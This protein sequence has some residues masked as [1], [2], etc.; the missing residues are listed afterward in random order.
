MYDPAKIPLPPN[1][2][3][4]HPFDNGELKVRDE[5]LAPFPRTPEVIREHI[6]AYYGMIS[7]LDAQVGRVLDALD[8]TGHTRDTIVIFAGDNGLAVGR[9]GLMGKQNLY[10][11]S[12]RVPLL[13]AA[14]GV[15][16]PG[17]RAAALCYLHDVFPTVCD[18]AGVPAP[19]TVESKSLAAV[20]R[21]PAAAAYENVCAAYRD[22][23][24]MVRTDRWKLIEYP[25]AGVTQ[26]FDVAADPWEL[27]NLAA[28][29]T[30]APVLA[31]MRSRLARQQRETGDPLAPKEA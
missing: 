28:D 23:Q 11:H 10:E 29:P 19:A 20:L 18:L 24:R 17:A 27:T 15:G 21:D 9:H 31:D 7:H 14:P 5:M 25:K 1:F 6:A 3:P 30:R 13:L 26:L 16:R 2:M 8:E 4:A 22:V 12:V